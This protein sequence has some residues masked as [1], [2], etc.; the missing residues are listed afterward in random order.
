MQQGTGLKFLL[1]HCFFLLG[2]WYK[3]QQGGSPCCTIFYYWNVL[4]ATKELPP[5]AA[6]PQKNIDVCSLIGL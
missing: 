2:I 1:L 6:L 4:A 3:A 5:A